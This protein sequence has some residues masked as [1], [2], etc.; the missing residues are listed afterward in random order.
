MCTILVANNNGGP[1]RRCDAR[2]YNAKGPHCECLC[3]GKNHGVG[4]EQA[5]A[6]VAEVA[7]EAE[8]EVDET[9]QLIIDL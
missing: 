8:L 9:T 5:L 4:I 2:C 3:G 1:Q 7:E 6:N